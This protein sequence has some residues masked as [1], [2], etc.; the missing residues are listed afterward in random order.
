MTLNAASLCPAPG[1]D[2]NL[3]FASL[4]DVNRA[5]TDFCAAAHD[6]ATITAVQ[7]YR[8][9]RMRLFENVAE[10]SRVSQYTVS[11]ISQCSPETSGQHPTQ[12]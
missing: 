9:F 1:S 12:N 2:S 10:H 6:I 5:G 4:G 11:C 8:V 7:Q 3:G